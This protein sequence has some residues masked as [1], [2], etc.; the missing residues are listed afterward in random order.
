M[1]LMKQTQ[2][3]AVTLKCHCQRDKAPLTA[4][5]WGRN[6]ESTNNSRHRDSLQVINTEIKYISIYVYVVW[7]TWDQVSA[8]LLSDSTL[9]HEK[10]GLK[11]LGLLEILNL[12]WLQ[13]TYRRHLR[14]FMIFHTLF[15]TVTTQNNQ[16]IVLPRLKQKSYRANKK[17][18]V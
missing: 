10:A 14:F 6:E 9:R 13:T 12:L 16:I 2:H 7:F 11:L 18:F 17:H 3:T 1:T 4:A 8:Q 15:G 5:T